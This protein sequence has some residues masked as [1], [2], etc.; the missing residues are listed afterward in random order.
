MISTDFSSKRS[1]GEEELSRHLYTVVTYGINETGGGVT[2]EEIAPAQPRAEA[3]TPETQR[4]QG[5]GVPTKP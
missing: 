4:K 2:W 5:P 3:P 1:T